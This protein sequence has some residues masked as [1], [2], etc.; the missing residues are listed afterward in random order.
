MKRLSRSLGHLKLKLQARSEKLPSGPTLLIG[1]ATILV[2]GGLIAWG[3]IEEDH[4]YPSSL[5]QN[6]GVAVLLLVPL[7]AVERSFT[8]RVR[9]TIQDSKEVRRDV[10]SVESRLGSAAAALDELGKDVAQELSVAAEADAELAETARGGVSVETIGALFDRAC[11]LAALSEH[12]LRV[13]V[14]HQW[15]RIRFTWAAMP[16]D[17]SIA[18][19]GSVGISVEGVRGDPL[20]IS[21]SWRPGQPLAKALASLAEAWKRAGSYPGDPII[22]AEKVISDLID[23][24]DLA[25]RSR[26]TRG[27]DQLSP[28]IEQLS[29]EWVLTNFGLEHLPYPYWIRRQELASDSELSDWRRHMHD[30]IWV[31]E[32]DERAKAAREPDF[33]MISEIAHQFFKAQQSQLS[34]SQG[35]ES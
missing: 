33:W 10:A 22:D 20:G 12:G 31:V 13:A 17:Q 27:E 19:E 24:L 34:G 21:T 18:D 2:G 3:W 26:R 5:L 4:S 32:E 28:L 25:I 16:G 11:E 15:E 14:P 9:Q 35:R 23:S 29:K 6:M 7:L 30:K 8:R 1:A